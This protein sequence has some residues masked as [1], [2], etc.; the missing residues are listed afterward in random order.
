M[1]DFMSNHGA[2]PAIVRVSW[3]FRI[4][5]NV[6]QNAGRKCHSVGLLVVSGIHDVDEV[7]DFIVE[8]VVSLDGSSQGQQVKFGP[9]SMPQRK[10]I[11]TLMI[12][13]ELVNYPIP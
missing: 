9:E 4:K 13:R 8:P 6:L 5:E 3:K 11:V 7:C 1:C 2:N 12:Q 10:I